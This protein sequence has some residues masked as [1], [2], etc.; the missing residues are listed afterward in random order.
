M[1]YWSQSEIAGP[2]AHKL[3]AVEVEMRLLGEL[4]FKGPK[5]QEN[6][7]DEDVFWRFGDGR[8]AY[9]VIVALGELPKLKIT[10]EGPTRGSGGE[11]YI[12]DLDGAG[13]PQIRT[14]IQGI[15]GQIRAEMLEIYQ[16]DE[17]RRPR[18]TRWNK[19]DRQESLRRRISE[20]R[21]PRREMRARR[22]L[23]EGQYRQGMDAEVVVKRALQFWGDTYSEELEEIGPFM[24][25][26]SARSVLGDEREAKGSLM[27]VALL[28]DQ[29]LRVVV[30]LS[31]RLVG[32]EQASFA[33]V[34]AEVEELDGGHVQRAS[35]GTT[36][37][38]G[39]LFERT[40][41]QVRAWFSK[42]V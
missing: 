15:L 5:V 31:V 23:V 6:R 14:W 7:Y 3:G 37:E 9:I 32:A 36:L 19:W 4:G 18:D 12:R 34:E 13:V 28:S 21:S 29:V 17:A 38:Q 1:V 27:L 41:D 22:R 30:E 33:E 35:W 26:R 40:L 2:W 11:S 25:N 20:S 8:D 10:W 24:E 42:R 39:R 16:D